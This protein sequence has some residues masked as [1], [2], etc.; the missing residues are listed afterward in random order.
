MPRKM[1]DIRGR[2]FGRLVVLDFVETRPKYQHMWL[3]QCDCGN[4]KIVSRSNLGRGV[5]SCGC[6]RLEDREKHKFKPKHGQSKSRLYGVWGSM[7]DRCINPNANEYENYGGRGIT[8][9]NEWRND[10][11]AFAEWAMANGYDEKSDRSHSLLD[12]ID[13]N[14]NYEPSNCRFV[15]M[16]AQSRNKRSNVLITYNG[17]THCLSEWAEIAGIRYGTFLKRLYAGWSMEDA[18]NKPL[19]YNR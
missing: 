18:M 6:K 10:Y 4:Q 19:A 15:T 5:V 8:V 3:C 1:E 9:C 11:V 7:V 16:K 2:R 17:E 12:R 14:G 13:V